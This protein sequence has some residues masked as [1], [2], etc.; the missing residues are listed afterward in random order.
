M[1]QKFPNCIVIPDEFLVIRAKKIDSHWLDF[2]VFE[3]ISQNVEATDDF[4]F[5]SKNVANEKTLDLDEA[6]TVAMGFIK[7]DGCMEISFS[8][9]HFCCNPKAKLN[10]LFDALYTELGPMMENFQG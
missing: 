10:A 5:A 1:E 6:E 2:E 3:M 8:Q 9:W 4:E 7:W